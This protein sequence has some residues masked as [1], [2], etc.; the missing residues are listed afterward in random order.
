MQILFWTLAAAVAWC[1]AGY[2]LF[3]AA[4]VRFRP[5][6]IRASPTERPPTVTVVIAL[7]NER[8]HLV[9][10]VENILAQEYPAGHLD[11]ILVCNGST[12][13]SETVAREL[14]SGDD[15][16]RVLV[17]PADQGKA[18]AINMALAAAQGEVTVFAD[19][20]QTFAPDAV[21]Q[22]VAPFTDPSVGAVTGRLLV[23]R[24]AL[25]S[26]E[27]VRLYWGLETQL[28]LAE[29]RS[30]SVVGAT[31]AI[32]AIRRELFPGIPPNLILDDV[33]VPLR[34]AMTR[35]R[36]VMAA[37]ALAYDVAA[38]DQRLEYAR[39]R[40]TMV[41]NIQL[42]RMTPGV[43]SPFRNPLFVRFFSHKLLR[44]LAPFLF[45]AML[46]L[47]AALSGPGY[48]TLFGAQIAL[49]ALGLVGLVVRVRAL[50]I[51]AAFV[52]VH[53]AVFAAVW[54]WRSDASQVWSQPRQSAPLESPLESPLVAYAAAGAPLDSLDAIAA[55]VARN[56]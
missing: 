33:Y 18:G 47:S 2:P 28:R 14:A 20:R 1:Y 43:L 51:P 23:A 38:T 48:R 9:R 45:V 44:L 24:S 50:S 13:G 7:R 12:D 29:S 40:R 49:Y 54:Q 41:G 25:A 36:V 53:A 21:R 31:G 52:L 34:I 27:G 11:L 4:Q 30:G 8:A 35:R 26:V 10:R 46:G 32:Y 56:A 37:D 22:L 15:R 17:S 42:V 6:P 39:K 19:A 55:H 5:R 3:V 16:V